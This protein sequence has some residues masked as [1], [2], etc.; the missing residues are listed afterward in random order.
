MKDAKPTADQLLAENKRLGIEL[1]DA[2]E[3]NGKLFDELAGLRVEVETLRRLMRLV[4]AHEA[5]DERWL[6]QEGM[7]FW[8][9]A[10][11]AL[12]EDGS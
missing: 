6:T 4:L 2:A 11:R 3:T 8:V 12:K 9:D 1:R 5:E 7:D 10:E